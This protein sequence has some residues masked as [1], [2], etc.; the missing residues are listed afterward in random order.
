M[1]HSAV[2]AQSSA[3]GKAVLGN[4]SSRLRR[5]TLL[6]RYLVIINLIF[7]AWYLYWR[8]T[9]SINFQAFWISIPLFLAELYSYCGGILFL[10]GLWRPLVRQVKSLKQMS[11]SIPEELL[12]TVDIFITCYNEPVDLVKETAKAA[13]QI[14]YPATKL[15]VYILDDGA[16]SQMQ[17]MADNLG[18]LD[19]ES[20]Q[21]QAAAGK[22]QQER[23]ALIT[24]RSTLVALTPDITESASVL[25]PFQLQVQSK[26]DQLDKVLNWFDTLKR[27]SIP[28]R[29]WLELVTA[30]G[31]V[32]DN[33]LEHAHKDLP[34]ETLITIE[35]SLLSTAIQIKIYDYGPELDLE[36]YFTQ[37]HEV[38][39]LAEGGRGLLILQQVADYHSYIRTTNDRNCF[40]LIKNYEPLQEAVTAT[41]RLTNFLQGFQQFLGLKEVEY[42]SPGEAIKAALKQLEQEI[43][44]KELLMANLIRCRYIARPKPKNKPHYAKAGNINY[45]L[46]SGGTTGDL[47]V[48]FD[49]DH[50]PKPSYLQQVVPYFFEYDLNT[51]EYKP[52]K[53]AFV[54]TPQAFSNLP[55]DDVFGHDAHLFY[56]PIQQAKDGMNSAFYTGTNATLRRE[57]LINMGLQNFAL[58]FE[59]DE[60]KLEDFELIGGV[61]SISITE[62][63]NT[64][65][66]LHAAGWHS[67][68][69]NEILAEGLAP[70][71]LASTMKQKLRWAQGTIQVLYQDNPLTKPGLSFWQRW[72][73]FQTMYSYFSGFFI[74]VF[75]LCP[76]LYFYTGIIPVEAYGAA[77]AIHFIPA[78]VLNRL[79]M[80][81]GAWGVPAQELWRCEQYAIAFFPLYIQAVWSVTTGRSIKFEVTPKQRQSGNYLKLVLP[82]LT[83]M[84]LTLG[85]II[86]C[87]IRWLNGDLEDPGLFLI[88]LGWSIYNLSLLWIVVRAAIWQPA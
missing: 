77:F 22:L 24:Q 33:V 10:I 27:D 2:G 43:H 65:M 9:A 60:Q 76:I 6:F 38:D 88:N 74:I 80:M 17:E 55:P 68:Y 13:L 73:Y 18:L 5:S 44:G 70:D 20:P 42:A 64:A 66:G 67:M 11:P 29:T 58:E 75:L 36:Y 1:S 14:D 32:F 71:D 21:M 15:A 53:V 84:M 56:G 79:T 37:S 45:A 25:E 8:G 48:T 47:F 19:L 26:N 63:M 3:P 50:I 49:A 4:F 57:A 52:N 81:A 31:E 61:S 83:I 34:S 85:G 62:D 54:Q 35:V 12:P 23:L 7:G 69:H 30:I 51:C 16:S 41:E 78:F 82:Q 72:Q 40:T 86:W 46:F 39:S 87:Q 28:E 59:E